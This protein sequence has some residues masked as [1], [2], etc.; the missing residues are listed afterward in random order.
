MPA[1]RAPSW[2]STRRRA[3]PWAGQ[4]CR[5][6]RRAAP[7]AGPETS[8]VREPPRQDRAIDGRLCHASTPPTRLQRR[9][10]PPRLAGDAPGEA[11][12]VLHSAASAA[13]A[14][15]LRSAFVNASGPGHG[16]I[17]GGAAAVGAW[18]EFIARNPLVAASFAA[19]SARFEVGPAGGAWSPAPDGKRR[20][21]CAFAISDNKS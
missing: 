3:R 7:H 13:L 17:E 19:A 1:S 18:A 5:G 8:L 12:P 14:H 9:R 4:P 15:W 16:T 2:R 10:I 11:S 6:G 20:P 21:R